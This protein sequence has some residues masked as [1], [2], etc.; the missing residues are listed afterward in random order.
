MRW[1]APNLAWLVNF[2]AAS[3]LPFRMS[4]N[5]TSRQRIAKFRD[6]ML[7]LGRM[8]AVA[9]LFAVPINKPAVN[10]LMALTLI[11]AVAGSNFRARWTLSARHPVVLGCLAWWA[12]LLMS[13]LHAWVAGGPIPP[14]GSSVYAL[15]YPLVIGTLLNVPRWRNY[16]LV[17][18]ALAGGLV[19]LISS[20]QYAG[21]APQRDLAQVTPTMRNTV[22]KEYTQQGLTFL[23]L[24]CM[25]WATSL[26]VKR[27][28][29][30]AGLGAVALLCLANVI[31][32]LQSRTAYVT[33]LLLLIY[34]AW[35]LVRKNK[36]GARSIMVL[37]TLVCA[38]IMMAWVVP[39][40]RERLVNSVSKEIA[41]YAT[42]REPTSTGIRLELWR[43]TLPIM[44]DAPVFG[45]GL[46]QWAVLYRDAIK[47]L[48]NFN[49]FLMGHP[50]QELLLIAAEEGIAG[51]LT[52][53]L[54]LGLL[55]RYIMNLHAPYRDTYICLLLIYVTA[56]LANG[57]WVDFSHRHVFIMLLACIPLCAPPQRRPVLPES[58][59]P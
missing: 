57:L 55:A 3:L 52:F 4:M 44:A 27:P 16:G 43:R 35:R 19:L 7:V 40:I 18:F 41:Q 29:H 32:A 20:A 39:S 34:G 36:A 14:S 54:L 38:G 37:V 31:W 33:L 13:G 45:H 17:S 24:A 1:H 48:P 47:D 49:A 22:F 42:Q 6:A 28:L 15:W 11:C 50:H 30:K 51:L 58:R 25:A 21:L 2:A 10:L 8:S 46:G 56:G 59:L 26:T 53:L 9:C 23:I 5:H 12:V